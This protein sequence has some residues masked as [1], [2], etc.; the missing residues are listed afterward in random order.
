[1]ILPDEIIP[2]Y[3]IRHIQ[4]PGPNLRK[5]CNVVVHTLKYLF[6]LILN[7]QHCSLKVSE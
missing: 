5:I 7:L 2:K 1:M 4:F 3:L 6:L